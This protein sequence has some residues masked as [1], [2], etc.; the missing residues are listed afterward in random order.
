MSAFSPRA[1][2]WSAVEQPKGADVCVL[3]TRVGMVRRMNAIENEVKGSPHARGDGPFCLAPTGRHQRFSPRAW[4]WSAASAFFSA[5]ST[6]LPTRVGM[7]RRPLQT[8]WPSRCSPHARGDGP[9]LLANIIAR[10]WFS[11]RAW[12]WS[13]EREQKTKRP[14]VLPTRVGMVRGRAAGGVQNE[15]SPHARGDGPLMLP[16]GV[17]VMLFSPRAWGWSGLDVPRASVLIVLP[18]RVG[19]VRFRPICCPFRARSPHAR[20][21]GPPFLPPRHPRHRFSP[22]AWG[23]S[24]HLAGAGLAAGVLPTRV[25][26]VREKRGPLSFTVRSPHARGDGPETR[27]EERSIAAFSPRAWGWSALPLESVTCCTVLPTRVGMVRVRL[28][29]SFG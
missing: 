20:G 1:W 14:D 27:R 28:G 2:G 23:W 16:A 8:C 21:D 5:S 24:E 4:G 17:G 11:P 13:G 9:A 18:T 19:M 7:V 3:P 15:R 6:V 22:R 29:K 10:H 25:G 26:M 12:G